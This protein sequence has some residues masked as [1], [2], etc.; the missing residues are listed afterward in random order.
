[1]GLM[2]WKTRFAI[3]VLSFFCG[4][5]GAF[6]AEPSAEANDKR[7]QL[8]ELFIWKTSEDLKLS[9][10]DERSF[11]DIIKTL[12]KKKLELNK[13]LH[14][15]VVKMAQDPSDKKKLLLLTQYKKTLQAYNHL[16]EEEIDKMKSLLGIQKLSQYLQIKQD[17]TRRV[18]SLLANPET[19][20][21]SGTPLPVPQVIEEDGV[22][23]IPQKSN[24]ETR[25][26]LVTPATG[27]TQ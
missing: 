27:I 10:A 21:R 14:D 25:P 16:S 24:H 20:K 22:K 7:N 3:L 13:E 1:M 9:P 11:T 26:P 12:N 17:I 2:S 6:A 23:P 8:E 4:I 18:K 5:S 15:T 19:L